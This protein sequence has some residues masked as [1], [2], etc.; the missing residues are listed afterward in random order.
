M[1][2]DV[3]DIIKSDYDE[4]A[5]TLIEFMYNGLWFI[6]RENACVGASGVWCKIQNEW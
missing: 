6:K 3:T 5:C 2:K 1:A 4:M